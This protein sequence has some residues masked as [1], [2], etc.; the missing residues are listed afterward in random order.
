MS[1]KFIIN[2]RTYNQCDKLDLYIVLIYTV[3]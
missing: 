2:I 3:I 1:F